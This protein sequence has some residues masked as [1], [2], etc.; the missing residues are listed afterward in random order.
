MKI[1][2]SLGA[3]EEIKSIL[4]QYSAI[5]YEVPHEICSL[6]P[7]SSS[8]A[9]ESGGVSSGPDQSPPAGRQDNFC[10]S[11]EERVPASVFRYYFYEKWATLYNETTWILAA[12]FKDVIFQ[13][14]PFVFRKKEWSDYQ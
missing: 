6:N 12:D 13:S 11:E 7:T 10:G 3:S 5:V 4:M 8:K 1:K 14:D 2:L 9:T